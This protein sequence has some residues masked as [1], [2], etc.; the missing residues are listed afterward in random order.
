MWPRRDRRTQPA[1]DFQQHEKRA[2]P[3]VALNTAGG[4]AVSA[5]GAAASVVNSTRKK[6]MAAT[7]PKSFL[8]VTSLIRTAQPT[9]VQVC[10]IPRRD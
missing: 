10:T 6:G 9:L 3:P 5:T 1:A 2:R 7:R 8:Y 4:A